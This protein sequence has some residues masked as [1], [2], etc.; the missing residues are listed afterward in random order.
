MLIENVNRRSQ[1]QLGKLTPKADQSKFV[2]GWGVVEGNAPP[3]WNGV[4][5][6]LDGIPIDRDGAKLMRFQEFTEN[7]KTRDIK[8]QGMTIREMVVDRETVNEANRYCGQLSEANVQRE[9]S[10]VQ[11]KDLGRL[12]SKNTNSGYEQV[13]QFVPT[14]QNPFQGAQEPQATRKGWPKGK[15]RGPRKKAQV[16]EPQ[17][18]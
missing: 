7:G 15:P 17:P 18:T 13:T 4:G 16:S 9:E 3:G 8:Y 5:E 14:N 12:F 10:N 11:Q 1:T 2:S 6:M